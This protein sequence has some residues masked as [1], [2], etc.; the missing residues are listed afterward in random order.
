MAVN[1][2]PTDT[3]LLRIVS[4][5]APGSIADV[6]AIMQR[7]DELLPN[8]DGLKW[9]NK[10][11]LMVT[12]QID[13]QSPQNGW[14]DAAWLTRLDV[15]FA[16]F[17]FA[18]I[19]GALRQDAGTASSWEA[20]FEARS[21]GGIDRIQF[22]LAG[23]NAHINH[24]LALALLQ[25]DD[26]L[27]LTPALKSSEHDDY[28]HVNVLLEAV[29]PAALTMLATGI[30]GELAQDTGKI[31]RLLAIWNVRAARDLAWDFAVQLRDLEGVSR[32]FA[33]QAQDQVTGVAGR[34]LLLPIS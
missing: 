33:L 34:S 21:R 9:F 5:A 15:V 10:L 19:A 20:L 2:D 17:Y 29:L 22:A 4:A 18:A 7:I 16:G 6:I 26:Q 25:T 23:M 12:Q 30:A 8:D 13:A 3:Q 32:D 24:D 1:L 14:K 27:H 31:G 11:Y 28:E